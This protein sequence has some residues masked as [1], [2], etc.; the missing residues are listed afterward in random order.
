MEIKIEVEKPKET[1]DEIRKLIGQHYNAIMP[2]YKL[3]SDSFQAKYPNLYR[4]YLRIAAN[5]LH[6]LTSIN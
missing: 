1:Y 4:L 5:G 3:S 2:G 6:K